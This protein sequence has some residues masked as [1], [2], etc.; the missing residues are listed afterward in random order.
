MNIYEIM[1][2]GK[3]PD[4]VRAIVEKEI[5]SAQVIIEKEQAAKKEEIKEA[6]TNLVNAFE[7]YYLA[8]TG[9]WFNS[10]EYDSLERILK[11]TEKEIV[12]VQTWLE[13]TKE[14]EPKKPD[15]KPVC[16]YWKPESVKFTTDDAVIKNFINNLV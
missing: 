3:T 11:E 10:E 13:K 9:K 12:T 1:K 16:N 6:R 14:T 15:K 8:L 7:D 2:S 4:E 5:K